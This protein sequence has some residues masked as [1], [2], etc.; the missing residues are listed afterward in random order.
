MPDLSQDGITHIKKFKVQLVKSRKKRYVHFV[1]NHD[2]T[3]FKQDYFA[4]GT[5]AGE[6]L[7]DSSLVNHI[8]ALQGDNPKALSLWSRY[9]AIGGL[10]EHTF[11]GKVIKL[12][13][14]YAKISI[15]LGE[16]INAD[17]QKTF[18][19]ESYAL[20]NVSDRG[21]VVPFITHGYEIEFPFSPSKASEPF[22][23]KLYQDEHNILNGMEQLSFIS[24]E[25]PYYLFERDNVQAE[26]KTYIIIRGQRVN[27][28]TGIHGTRYYKID[29]ISRKQTGP[30][31]FNKGISSYF[32]FI[33]NKHYIV[34]IG[35]IDSDGYAT[36]E[37]AVQ[38]PA[39]NNIFAD[40]QLEDFKKISDG[41]FFLS[42]DP[43]QLV[44]VK[45]GT[46][47][48]NTFYSATEGNKLVKFYPSW[49][50][51]DTQTPE[52]GYTYI[53]GSDPFMGRLTKTDTGF[54][55]EVKDIPNDA[56]KFYDIE[57]V[58]LR[59][60]NGVPVD[61]ITGATAPLARKVRI[62][63]NQ[64]YPFRG[65]ITSG[66][67]ADTRNLTFRVYE[68]DLIPKTL[69]PFPVYIKADGLTPINKSG[70]HNM[71]IEQIKN[72]TT[73]K[74]EVL[75]KYMVQES[76]QQAGTVTIPF[77]VNNPDFGSGTITLKAEYYQNQLIPNDKIIYYNA[78]LN[79][80]Y[81]KPIGYSTSS[82]YVPNA[83]DFVFKIYDK[84]LTK[85]SLADDYKISFEPSG[86]GDGM[87]SISLPQTLYEA[88]KGKSLT[89]TAKERFA[90]TD[91]GYVEYTFTK[92][93]TVAEWMK[94]YSVETSTPDTNYV[95]DFSTIAVSIVGRLYYYSWQGSYKVFKNIPPTQQPMYYGNNS[96]YDLDYYDKVDI[97][98]DFVCNQ[99]ASYNHDGDP[100][101]KFTLNSTNMDAFKT[102]TYLMLW[103]GPEAHQAKTLS[104]LE[105]RPYYEIEIK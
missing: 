43:I 67:T 15:K 60:Y 87:F 4:V 100:Y 28:L 56:T 70:I 34:N 29:L 42:V 12:L 69:F 93:M 40:T 17:P 8:A 18:T 38:A 79:L 71:T 81:E 19:L 84:E 31:E 103:Y 72:P 105:S 6:F 88:Y 64:P 25:K 75:Y 33:R 91:I 35:R 61:G 76:D 82:T 27:T 55:I 68:E 96:F 45:P 23:T 39:G 32:P 22:G 53:A 41:N 94:G 66:E 86:N 5:S 83:A 30:Q 2:W 78:R 73:G 101:F 85:Q 10:D 59:K 11:D 89:I 77:K 54:E 63:I 98:S 48:F 16:Q 74:I 1:A 52:A 99:T 36:L 20:C 50:A 21:S 51:V 58:A 49:D 14:N 47:S 9:E 26:K 37:E 80:M 57:V 65:K 44:I 90:P 62:S 102:K 95:W 97:S 104:E 92:T 3:G 7:T 13:R 24:S 46:Y